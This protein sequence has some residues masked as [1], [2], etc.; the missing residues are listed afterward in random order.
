[1]I[2]ILVSLMRLSMNLIVI[3]K[4]RKKQFSTPRPFESIV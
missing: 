3:V 4:K 2:I 1:M